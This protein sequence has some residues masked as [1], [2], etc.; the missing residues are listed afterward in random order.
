MIIHHVNDI[1]IN[2]NLNVNNS[3]I[4][5]NDV[6]NIN[7]TIVDHKTNSNHVKVAMIRNDVSTSTQGLFNNSSPYMYIY[8]Y[9][10]YNTYYMI[11]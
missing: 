1:N 8:I 6:V 10:K 4:I 7:D 9:T 3:S 2:D 11:V 5:A